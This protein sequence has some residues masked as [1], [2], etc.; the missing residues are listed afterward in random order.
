M[1]KVDTSP[2]KI[3]DFL[4]RGV[5]ETITRESV[6]KKLASGKVLRVKHGVDPSGSELH[7]GHA[8]VYLKLRDLQE[9]GHKIIF[10]VGGFT[11]R[12]GDPTE[13]LETRTLKSKHD[14][15]ENA[16]NYIDQISKLLDVKSIEVATNSDWYDKMSAEE[17]IKLLTHFTVDQVL[18]RDMFRERKKQN[19]PIQLHETVYP[20]LQ[21]YDSV[22]LKSD[23]TVVGTDQIF[24]E[25]FGRDLQKKFGQEPQD[26]V[27]IKI[28]SG[29]DGI[30]KMSKSLKNFIALNDSPQD[31]FGKV[32]S[33]PDRLII[34]YFILATRVA[35]PKI[36][37]MEL[38]LQDK[39]VNPMELKLKLAKE[40]VSLYH[41][42]EKALEAEEYFTKTFSKKEMPV[43]IPLIKVPENKMK[44]LNVVIKSGLANSKSEARRL[45]ESGATDSDGVSILSPDQ[46]V[47]L[48]KGITVRVGKHRFVKIKTARE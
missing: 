18:E 31:Q 8:S 41:S 48:E 43:D 28:L 10:L 9:M 29:L 13:K 17:F 4:E 1:N 25:S 20:I 44:W 16:K 40:I 26:I 45:I 11:G 37:E 36:K 35:L 39:S 42:G 14:A 7:L 38:A 30:R 12:F 22:M 15:E 23:L 34:D 3:N 24:N 21:G 27:A 46:M 2:Q 33:L 6:A 5:V 47:D 32:M 19:L